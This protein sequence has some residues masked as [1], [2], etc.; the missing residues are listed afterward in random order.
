MG[1]IHDAES[2]NN[3]MHC[4]VGLYMWEFFCSLDFEWAVI[5]GKRRFRW[6]MVCSVP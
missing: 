3:L 1:L 2:F 6:P 4:L 5:T